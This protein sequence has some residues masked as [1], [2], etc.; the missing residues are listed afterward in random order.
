MPER[1]KGEE[2]KRD[3]RV[4]SETWGVGSSECGGKRPIRQRHR[5]PEKEL[6]GRNGAAKRK[7]V[8]KQKAEWTLK[9]KK[10]EAKLGQKDDTGALPL[11]ACLSLSS[12]QL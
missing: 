9:T 7:C 12:S 4:E 6:R 11:R 1:S 5:H 10:R 8:R 3:K 2:M